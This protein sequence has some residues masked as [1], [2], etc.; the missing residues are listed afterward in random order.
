MT[1][2]KTSTTPVDETTAKVNRLA[3]ETTAKTTTTPAD[4]TTAKVNRLTEETNK[5][6]A[7]YAEQATAQ[8]KKLALAAIES[9]EDQ[10]LRA[11][12]SYEKAVADTKVD[13]LKDLVAPQAAAHRELTTAYVTAA[14]QLVN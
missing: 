6:L 7:E 12:D 13:W 10:V 11:V 9:Y 2:A 5:K 1:T 14:R 4:E 3:G 8:Q